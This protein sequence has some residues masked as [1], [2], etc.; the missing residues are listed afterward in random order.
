MTYTDLATRIDALES[1]VAINRLISSYAQAFD[2]HD[3]DLLKSIWHPDARL[4]LGGDLGEEKGV[5]AILKSARANWAV[6]PKMHHW[7]ANAII[8]IDGDTATGSAA[9]DCL[10]IH[11]EQGPLQI[12]GLYRD[13]YERRDRVWGIVDRSFTMHFLTPL[14]NWKSVSG[15]EAKQKS[16]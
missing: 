8:D 3:E 15:S 10:C 14:Q 7:M 12:S 6:M 16:A 1:H 4:A 5:D 11:I 2:N 9:V 13:Y